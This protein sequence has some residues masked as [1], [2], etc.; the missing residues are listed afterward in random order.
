MAL[1]SVAPLLAI[2]GCGMIPTAQADELFWDW[3]SA[4]LSYQSAMGRTFAAAPFILSEG[5][6]VLT[7]FSW[8]G[9]TVD[10]RPSGWPEDHFL[11]TI[12]ED[13]GGVP[14]ESNAVF[15]DWHYSGDSTSSV[16]EYTHS[17]D[18]LILTP[19]RQYHLMIAN[20]YWG[21]LNEVYSGHVL[22][23]WP[24]ASWEGHFSSRGMFGFWQQQDGTLALQLHTAAPDVVPE[25][26]NMVL[27]GLGLAGLVGRRMR[28]NRTK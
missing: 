6:N 3:D 1:R 20:M 9:W 14:D 22:G 19:D 25:P 4:T 23:Y 5:Q 28:K 16:Q 27:L 11:L 7:G 10:Y 15:T 24:Y 8:I 12:F 18:P 13:D 26:A 2:I 17:I 21:D